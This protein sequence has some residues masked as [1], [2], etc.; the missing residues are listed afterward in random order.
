MKHNFRRFLQ[1]IALR[2][3]RMTDVDKYHKKSYPHTRHA[4][5]ICAN[6]LSREDS[7]LLISPISQKRYIKNDSKSLFVIIVDG[8]IT[9]VNHVYSYTINISSKTH[10]TIVNMFDTQVEKL[11]QEMEQEITSNVRDSLKEI[12]NELKYE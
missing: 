10:R 9:I 6:L 8:S 12:H 4:I 7:T 1:R 11:R 2:L 3:F 5:S